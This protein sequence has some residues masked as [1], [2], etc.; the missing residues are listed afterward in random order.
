ME[1]GV[2]LL[3]FILNINFMV[4]IAYALAHLLIMQTVIACS[5][6]LDVKK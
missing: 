3:S 6:F 4:I 5:I 1:T 2:N